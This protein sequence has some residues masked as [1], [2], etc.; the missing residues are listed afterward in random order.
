[1]YYPATARGSPCTAKRAPEPLQGVEWVVQGLDACP[2]VFGGG[3]GSQV[4][5][6]GPGRPLGLPVPGTLRNA[7]SGPIT[8]RFDLFY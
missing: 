3:G 6:S 4:P 1:M 2:R 5:P 7:A 8:A